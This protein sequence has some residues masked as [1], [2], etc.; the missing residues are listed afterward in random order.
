MKSIDLNADIGEGYNN[1]KELL[2]YISS[3]NIACGLHA[4]SP[5]IMTE[6]IQS[7]ARAGVAIGAHPGYPDKEGFGRV[8]MEMSDRELFS[9]ISYQIGALDALVSAAGA[10]MSH[11]KAHGALYNTSVCDPRIATTIIMAVKKFN[12]GLKVFGPSGSFLQK[13][14]KKEKL[15][16]VSEV[17]A[18]R[19]YNDDAGLVSRGKP[20]ALINDALEAAERALL[21]IKQGKVKTISGKIIDI[22]AQTICL[23]GDNKEAVLFAK[24]LHSIINNSGIS[25][26]A[27]L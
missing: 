8:K 19:G 24:E 23:H 15:D 14:A 4:G 16:F 2:E 25:I 22:K 27:N 5:I 12:P 18:D 21:M 20:G 11:I 1:D 6:T 17:F 3:A 9:V 26:K 13:E 10:K 7:A